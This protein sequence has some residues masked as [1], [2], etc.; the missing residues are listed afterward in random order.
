MGPHRVDGD[1]QD[2]SHLR[3]AD[4]LRRPGRHPRLGRGQPVDLAQLL[5][6]LRRGHGTLCRIGQQQQ[7]AGSRRGRQDLAVALHLPHRER[8]GLEGQGH[9]SR[10][11][12]QR[13]RRVLAQGRA[14]HQVPQQARHARR[15]RAQVA[16]ALGADAVGLLQHPAG[17]TVRPDQGAARIRQHQPAGEPVQDLHQRPV[18]PRMGGGQPVV[19]LRGAAQMRGQPHQ[20]RRF[21]RAEARGAARPQQ[22]QRGLLRQVRRAEGEAQPVLHPVRPHP[23]GEEARALQRRRDLPQGRRRLPGRAGQHGRRHR[24]ERVVAAAIAAHRLL[25]KAIGHGDPG[26]HPRLADMQRRRGAAEQVR[27]PAQRLGPALRRHA[28]LVDQSDH[29]GDRILGRR[30]QRQQ[31][32]PADLGTGL[33]SRPNG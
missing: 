30:R 33:R 19:H 31:G 25:G 4:P 7:H 9:L 14:V 6:E 15:P 13:Q 16:L 10:S 32:G 22:A 27:K 24:V 5:A 8:H 3:Q 20:Q 12:W 23:V 1:A 21:R 17:G 26:R 29:G 28:G 2:L 18:R 11:P